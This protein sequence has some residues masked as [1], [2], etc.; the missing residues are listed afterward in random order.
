VAISALYEQ[1]DRLATTLYDTSAVLVAHATEGLRQRYHFSDSGVVIFH[2]GNFQIGKYRQEVL[3]DLSVFSGS[4]EHIIFSRDF[5]NNVCLDGA[6]I[7][8]TYFRS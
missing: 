6:A 3:R 5:S 8:A 1:G 4:S 2:G 7:L